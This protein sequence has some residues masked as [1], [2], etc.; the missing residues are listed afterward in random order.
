MVNNRDFSLAVH[1]TLRHHLSVHNPLLRSFP[2]NFSNHESS[3]VILF[4][5]Q[6]ALI[7]LAS[8]N[9]SLMPSAT[10]SPG[11]HSARALRSIYSGF[12]KDRTVTARK[13]KAEEEDERTFSSKGGDD[14]FEGERIPGH[15]RNVFRQV[16]GRSAESA[17]ESAFDNWAP[18][19]EVRVIGKAEVGSRASERKEKGPL[20]AEKDPEE[21]TDSSGEERQVGGRASQ[22]VSI[23]QKMHG[24]QKMDGMTGSEPKLES[25]WSAL[26]RSLRNRRNEEVEE[27]GRRGKG[28]SDGS[29]S[30]SGREDESLLGAERSLEIREDERENDMKR[31]LN[32][33][34]GSL[35][36]T[37][38]GDPSSNENP[39][40][41]VSVAAE[42]GRERSTKK[43]DLWQR[44]NG[45]SSES[46]LRISVPRSADRNGTELSGTSAQSL[47]PDSRT[48]TFFSR[49]GLELDDRGLPIGVG[50]SQ[51][52]R[53][54]LGC[55]SPAGKGDRETDLAQSIAA[56]A[57]NRE[58]RSDEN[59]LTP[60]AEIRGAQKSARGLGD[61]AVTSRV[62][63]GRIGGGASTWVVRSARG[64]RKS[65]GKTWVQLQKR[66]KKAVAWMALS[67]KRDAGK[68]GQPC[69]WG[70]SDCIG[71]SEKERNVVFSVG[72][73]M[74]EQMECRFSVIC[75]YRHSVLEREQKSCL[76]L[77]LLACRLV[78]FI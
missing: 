34:F 28:I 71:S 37:R 11:V 60:E 21:G 13:A 33:G 70:L 9:D 54:V 22:R 27:K 40:E 75:R 36:Y 23:A 29:A 69:S 18:E 24:K 10:D 4:R 42:R 73:R 30:E 47:G 26:Q 58:W 43:H 31:N 52:A 35:F 50:G 74:K 32:S 64:G 17:A 45:D 57:G 38:S 15:R 65:I 61:E 67:R 44:R 3:L 72:S 39:Y 16:D 68:V 62:L 55:E 2:I 49:K 12:A 53:A 46:S 77:L 25:K 78:R 76:A 59:Y 14:S 20:Y 51:Y 8:R 1:N 41:P 63:A 19:S 6:D 5:Y 56:L 7:S 48:G 66:V